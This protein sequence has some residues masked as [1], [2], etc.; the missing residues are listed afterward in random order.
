M[1][2]AVDI[3]VKKKTPPTHSVHWG[4]THPTPKKH[5]K[6]FFAK[7]PLK[8]TNYLSHPF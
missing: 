6:F 4:L 2:F 1:L 8:S 7:P 5:H 3:C